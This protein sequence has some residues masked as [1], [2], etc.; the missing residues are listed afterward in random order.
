MTL[1]E[2]FKKDHPNTPMREDG[3]PKICP[4]HLGYTDET[5]RCRGM[6]CVK[7]WTREYKGEESN[8]VGTADKIADV[9]HN[10]INRGLNAKEAHSIVLHLI[11]RGYF[12]K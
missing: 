8:D 12:E 1:L 7:C 9:Y 6:A 5:D 10:I 11:D 2:K 3:T 4:F